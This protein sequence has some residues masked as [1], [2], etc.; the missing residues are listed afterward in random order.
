MQ[1]Q[2]IKLSR[3]AGHLPSYVVQLKLWDGTVTGHGHINFMLLN[4]IR[5]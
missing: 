2:T 1:I 4:G 5:F 3:M